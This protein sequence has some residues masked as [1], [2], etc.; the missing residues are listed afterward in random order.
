MIFRDSNTKK[1]LVDVTPRKAPARDTI[2]LAFIRKT[3]GE[4]SLEV[5]T[6]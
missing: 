6:L 5:C 1:Y 2:L 3:F 4:I